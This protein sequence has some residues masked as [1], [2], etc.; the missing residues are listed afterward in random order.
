[1]YNNPEQ[2]K[3]GKKIDMKPYRKDKTKF[4]TTHYCLK[5]SGQYI[6]LASKVKL[7]QKPDSVTERYEE[8]NKLNVI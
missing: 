5:P 2:H 6:E 1:L 4:S 3:G 8:D 7:N